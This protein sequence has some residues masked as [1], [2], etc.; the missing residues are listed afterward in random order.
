MTVGAII[1]MLICLLA[2]FGG[3]GLSLARLMKVSKRQEKENE[4]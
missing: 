3:F 4:N 1:M 2:V